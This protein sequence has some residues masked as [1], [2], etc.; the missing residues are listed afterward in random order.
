MP[1]EN[2]CPDLP[3]HMLNS[4][5][6]PHPIVLSLRHVESGPMRASNTRGVKMQGQKGVGK[7]SDLSESHNALG[8]GESWAKTSI[9]ISQVV[10]PMTE[11]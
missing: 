7:K 2:W 11:L 4:L 1:N 5:L 3:S 10:L 8:H 6:S 9:T